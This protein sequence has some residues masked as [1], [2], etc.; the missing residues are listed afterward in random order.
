MAGAYDTGYHDFDSVTF[1][2]PREVFP[3]WSGT[4]SEF[5]EIAVRCV[6]GA[7]LD[8][9]KVDLKERLGLR[10]NVY[11]WED[12][13]SVWLG[14]VRNERTILLV[15]LGFFM[16][17]V[18]TITF[19]VL[20]MLVQQKV[21]DIGILSSMGASAGGVA[22]VF[23]LSGVMIATLGGI[24][25]LAGGTTLNF[26]LNAVKDWI[27]ET[28]GIEVFSKEVYA[29]TEIPV[30][31]DH[32]LNVAIALVTILFAVVTCLIPA[33]RAGRLDPVEALR[34]D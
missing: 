17:L 5:S 12:Q 4:D 2:V 16:L 31:N 1:F 32:L 24:F 3:A 26:K 27:E 15:L 19:S 11:T 14:A 29:F 20:T 8:L 30:A 9:V 6:P 25:G 10:A 28:F 13:H 34:H 23:A 33:W 7:D 21:R 18:V 22:S